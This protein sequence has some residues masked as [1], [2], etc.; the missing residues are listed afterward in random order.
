MIALALAGG[1]IMRALML[2][3]LPQIDVDTLM[4]GNL[5]KNL[6]HGRF[7]ITDSAG[8]VHPTLLRLPGYPLFLAGCFALFGPDNYTAVNVLQILMELAGCLLLADFVRRIFSP[9]AALWTLLLGAL[10]PF[11]ASYSVA[12]LTETPTLFCIALALWSLDRFRSRPSW[13]SGL[14]FTFAVTFAALLRPDGALV[15]ISLTP[16]LLPVLFAAKASPDARSTLKRD[17]HSLKPETR[18]K[19][20]RIGAVCLLLALIPFVIW[21]IRNERVFHVFQPLAPRYAND[22]S[23]P[24]NAGWQRWMKTWCLDFVSTYDI[25]WNVPGS[26]FDLAKLP[27]R[28]FDTPQQY[29]ETKALADAYSDNG[30]DLSAEI[31]DGFGRLAAERVRDNPLRYYVWLPLGRVADMWLRPRVENLNID[32][33]WW[34]YSHHYAETR[35]SWAYAGLNALYLLL[36]LDWPVRSPAVLAV[37]AAL[38]RAAQRTAQHHRGARGAVYAG[39]LPD[40][41]CS[42]RHWD[43][44]QLPQSCGWA[45]FIGLDGAGPDPARCLQSS[46]GVLKDDN[47]RTPVAPRNPEAGMESDRLIF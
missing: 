22:P 40:A 43:C 9:G 29:A 34:V 27:S 36:A 33:D 7:A 18:Q 4:Y 24:V 19:V 44:R 30:Q 15:F 38:L 45:F 12:P 47:R 21:T 42:R 14:L 35:F 16:A 28:A 23:E 32:L 3:H 8:V 5:A 41:V 37:H 6:L 11:T 46:F 20:A 26:T 31:D 10:C 13:G 25:Y 1:A 39:V 17:V 2:R